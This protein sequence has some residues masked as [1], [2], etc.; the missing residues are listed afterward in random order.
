[1]A[2]TRWRLTLPAGWCPDQGESTSGAERPLGAFRQSLRCTG[3]TLVAVRHVEIRQR[4][5]EPQ[6]FAALS[7]VALAE[8]RANARR[9]RLDRL[10][11]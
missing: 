2:E 11:G 3:G 1:V 7:D 5:I 6:D 8:H 4:W 10:G 9:L